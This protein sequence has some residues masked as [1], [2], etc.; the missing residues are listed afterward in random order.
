MEGSIYTVDDVSDL[1]GIPRPTL[2]R[3]LREYSIPHLR[4][5]GRIQ[6]PEDSFDRIREARDLHKEGLGTESV[7]RQIREG[8][9]DTGELDRRLNSLHDTLEDLR[10]DLRAKP[11]TGEVALSP[12]LQTILAR[13]SLMLSAMFNL[14][15]MVEDL[16]L[17][18]GKTRKRPI[19]RVEEGLV[20]HV[21]L[22]AEGRGRLP[23]TLV[24]EPVAVREAEAPAI[25]P[26]GPDLSTSR[27]GALGRRRRRGA[28][29]ILSALLIGLLLILFLPTLN[30]GE[31]A[32]SDQPAPG[33][34]EQQQPPD[35]RPAGADPDE[36]GEEGSGGNPTD[37]VATDDA[38]PQTETTSPEQSTRTAQAPPSPGSGVP[39]VSG[40][41]LEEA[42]RNLS[43]A[44]YTVAAI[45]SVKGREEPGTV[46]GTE[47][48][49][50]T[51]ARPNAP[52]VLTVSAGP[53]GVSSAAA[54]SEGASAASAS[55]SANASSARASAG[56]ISSASASASA[57]P[58]P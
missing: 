46:T 30:D 17:N 15:G 21:P 36:A 22:R 31:T 3:Y 57:S 26:P 37:D 6:I 28:L 41:P 29:A 8:A 32:T 19:A 34:A 11:A 49:P 51:E 55:A 56:S 1:L 45:R 14:T 48:A 33:N 35:E 43:E 18:N 9:P 13:Q 58:S 38:P 20:H 7:R 23:G 27:F 53:T 47:P 4:Q 24:A 16:L 2:Y 25:A 12:V 44:G 10:G 50:G 42:A 52:V 54:T 40:Q 5:G 39:D